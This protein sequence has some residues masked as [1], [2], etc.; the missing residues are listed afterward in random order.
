MMMMVYQPYDE[1]VKRSHTEMFCIIP[2]RIFLLLFVKVLS[3]ASLVLRENN[4]KMNEQ[5]KGNV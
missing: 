3:F 2:T 5:T 4:T 1:K